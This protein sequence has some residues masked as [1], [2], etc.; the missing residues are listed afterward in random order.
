[1]LEIE[2]GQWIKESQMRGHGRNRKRDA[3]NRRIGKKKRRGTKPK[4]GKERKVAWTK[5]STE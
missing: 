1:M 3:V 2:N 5:T 4:K